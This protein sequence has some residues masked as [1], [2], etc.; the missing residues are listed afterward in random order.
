MS[1]IA[2]NSPPSFSAQELEQVADALV[3]AFDAGE[4]TRAL[5]FKMGIVLANYVNTQQGFSGV[6]ADFLNWTERRKKTLELI[7][8]AY[9]E[10]PDR[11]DIQQLA[12]ARGLSLAKAREKYDL[13]KAL[14][15]KPPSL[16]A[17]VVRHSR[18]IDYG[19]FLR[20]FESL[21]DR[22]CRIKTPEMMG[23]GFL[24]GPDFVL[25]N[26][27]V[28]LDVMKAP[29]RSGDVICTFDYRPG[30]NGTEKNLEKGQP[31]RCG[32]A[33]EWLIAK[34]PYAG[35]DIG[36]PGEPRPDELDYALLRLAERLG[37]TPGMTGNKRGWFD[38]AGDRP[39]L[40]VRDFVVIPQHASGNTLTVAWGNV[41]SFNPAT[42]RVRYDATTNPGSSGSPCFTADLE[43]FGLHHATDPVT[44][45]QFN[46]A[47][48]LDLIGADL[49]K[50]NLGTTNAKVERDG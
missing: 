29:S 6:V 40:P 30:G 23:T 47:V 35:S 2:P 11:E 18:L 24:V 36:Q 28:V 26:Y 48:P 43:I 14:P 5:R 41:L 34:S 10:R 13:T 45:P 16:E 21:G 49:K 50:K 38:L 46:Q 39:L 8:L 1:E 33:S 9:V 19:T 44:N 4:L 15:P 17:M 25:T 42:T 3:G 7:A 12:Q 32:L 31:R 20:R 27:H 37:D 22:V